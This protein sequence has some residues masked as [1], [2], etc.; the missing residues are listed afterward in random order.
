MRGLARNA[1][2]KNDNVARLALLGGGT[3]G[4]EPGVRRGGN[5]PGN[6]A[7]KAV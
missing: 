4:R 2:A 5:V 6:L 3:R 7:G 1:L